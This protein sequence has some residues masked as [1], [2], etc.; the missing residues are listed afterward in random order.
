MIA[1][2]KR[3]AFATKQFV[4]ASYGQDVEEKR[5]IPTQQPKKLLVKNMKENN[6]NLPD[7]A[8]SAKR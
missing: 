4:V 7:M 2:N 3:T 1:Q 6:H 8:G 5:V